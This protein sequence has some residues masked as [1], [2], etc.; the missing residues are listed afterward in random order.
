MDKDIPEDIPE[1]TPEDT[2]EKMKDGQELSLKRIEGNGKKLSAV[3]LNADKK[4]DVWLND[5]G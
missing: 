2:P 3:K 1:D 4:I 5:E